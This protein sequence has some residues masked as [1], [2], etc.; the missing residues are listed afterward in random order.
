MKVRIVTPY[1]VNSNSII[2]RLARHFTKYNGWP[3]RPV[4]HPRAVVNLFM[5]YTQ[6]RF[7]KFTRTPTAAW[8]THKERPETEHGA[9]LRRWEMAAKAVDLRVTPARLYLEEL[10]ECGRAVQ[11]EHPVELKHFTPRF[12]NLHDKPRVGIAG[13]A[14]AG[15]RK[16]EVL[17]KRL[18]SKYG[19]ECEIRTCGRGWPTPGEYLPWAKMPD[20]YRSLDVFLCTSLIEG[21]PVTVLEALGCGKIEATVIQPIYLEPLP[22]WELEKFRGGNVTVVELSCAGQFASLL[23]EKVGIKP[24]A[25][26]KKYDGRAFD[27]VGL[28]SRIKE[29]I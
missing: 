29:V 4:P 14:Y 7:E 12:H 17:V 11:I 28:A 22:V 23:A 15:G 5:P 27:P 1:S 9:P 24:R 2:A 20:F 21:G 10:A 18:W 25:V 16:G 26:V 13:R 3:M 6:W 8:F 19:H